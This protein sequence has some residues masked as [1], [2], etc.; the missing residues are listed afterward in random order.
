MKQKRDVM[1]S[2]KV[3][4]SDHT[5]YLVRATSAY[6]AKKKV[7]QNIKDGFTYGWENETH[8]LAHAKAERK[9]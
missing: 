4:L 1:H 7:W 9:D 6:L 5:S 3:H 8:F 2:Y